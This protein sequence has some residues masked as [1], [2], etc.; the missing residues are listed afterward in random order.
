[1]SIVNHRSV[2]PGPAD[3]YGYAFVTPPPQR[4][5]AFPKG[6]TIDDKILPVRTIDDAANGTDTVKELHG[7]DLYFLSEGAQERRFVVEQFYGR[8]ETSPAIPTKFN[9]SYSTGRIASGEWK[10]VCGRWSEE[11]QPTNY[12]GIGA[13]YIPE[14]FQ[15][16]DAGQFINVA[17]ATALPNSVMAWP[18]GTDIESTI[19]AGKPS[20]GRR[21]Y[22]RPCLLLGALD[23]SMMTSHISD[24]SGSKPAFT[25]AH[26]RA[27]F[28]DMERLRL[29]VPFVSMQSTH[30]EE[31]LTNP[32]KVHVCPLSFYL[33]GSGYQDWTPSTDPLEFDPRTIIYQY[34]RTLGS[35]SSLRGY[36]EKWEM[37]WGWYQIPYC[38]KYGQEPGQYNPICGE[39]VAVY[40]CLELEYGEGSSLYPLKYGIFKLPDWT[41]D[42]SGGYVT[43][44]EGD[45][46]NAAMTLIAKY[47]AE[48]PEEIPS[49]AT[50]RRCIVRVASMFS[51]CRVADR[52]DTTQLAW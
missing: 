31:D 17:D 6:V 48:I 18:D 36:W 38:G 51:V 3:P 47:S 20:A 52:T 8:N 39:E 19:P 7:V 2:N 10:Q 49:T 23:Q 50:S 37:E 28:R 42:R 24:W 46:Y 34:A 13:S 15:Y 27:L 25:L 9:L 41:L 44:Y 45:L 29:Y 14:P 22:E 1:M 30:R 35:G 32:Y 5:T 40:A 33:S 21:I 4:T 11:G 12:Q 43:V 26:V 16:Y